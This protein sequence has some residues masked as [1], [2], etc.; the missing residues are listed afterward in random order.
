MMNGG[1]RVDGST[2]TV[3]D[4]DW[5]AHVGTGCKTLKDPNTGGADNNSPEE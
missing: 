4:K 5:T 1:G 3:V 2:K